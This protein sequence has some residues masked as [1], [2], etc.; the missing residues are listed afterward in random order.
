MS[1]LSE[2]YGGIYLKPPDIPRP[3]ILTVESV[4]FDSLTDFKDRSKKN[5]RLVFTFLECGKDLVVNKFSADILM[6]AW[7]DDENVYVGKQ[8]VLYT[9]DTNIAGTMRKIIM[10]RLP[11]VQASTAAAP[12]PAPPPVDPNGG[13]FDDDIP[14]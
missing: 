2:A 6:G 11:R 10:L 5:D 7:G 8:V 3:T 4:R 14:F 1:R 9:T 12:T 13:D